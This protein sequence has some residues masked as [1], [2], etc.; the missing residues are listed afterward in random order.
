MAAVFK[1]HRQIGYLV[2]IVG[3]LVDS[4]PKGFFRFAP[5]ALTEVKITQVYIQFQLFTILLDTFLDKL[6]R[7]F[8]TPKLNKRLVI[9]LVVELA[10][11]FVIKRLIQLS[12]LVELLVLII[13]RSH[14]LIGLLGIHRCNTINTH[15]TQ[16]TADNT[17]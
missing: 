7:L 3:H 8:V 2:A 1:S 9:H 13:I 4:L 5:F 10:L 16:Q 12:G 11:G 17:V 6:R 14:L 15:T